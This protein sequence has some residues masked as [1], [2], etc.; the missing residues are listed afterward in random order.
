MT[1]KNQIRAVNQ[2]AGGSTKT[3][4]GRDYMLTQTSSQLKRTH[5]LQIRSF[6]DLKTSHLQKLVTGWAQQGIQQR[7]VNNR[8]AAIRAALNEKGREK[9]AKA[10]VNSNQM[11]WM[12]ANGLPKPVSA[13]RKGTHAVIPKNV[14]TGR[15]N[16][17]P[18]PF[19]TVASLQLHLGLRAR[20]AVLA[21]DTLRT[22][23]KQL[24]ANQPLTVI[25][26]TKTGKNRDVHILNQEH[27]EVLKTLI[28]HAIALQGKER[29]LIPAKGKHPAEA[30]LRKFQRAMN[31]VGF[32][33]KEASHA[34]RYAWAK[35]Q[36]ARR[37]E[38]LG[39]RRNALATLSQDLGHGDGR[40][41]Y[42]A[43][44]YLS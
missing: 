1:S 6:A 9:F 19:K 7:T 11:L 12:N 14:I 23:E 20:E 3:K 44:V 15:I 38:Q 8:L 41:R 35:E 28:K 40:G 5:N 31:K 30:A 39:D 36:Y 42:C 18:E 25:Y 10:E 37:L 17:L 32:K 4:I 2:H 26:G 43:H 22:W 24:K 16:T 21:G 34:I 27:K 33:G 29:H 13:S